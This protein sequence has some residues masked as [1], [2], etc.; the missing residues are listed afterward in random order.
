MGCGSCI[1]ACPVPA[2]S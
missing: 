2:A 1:S